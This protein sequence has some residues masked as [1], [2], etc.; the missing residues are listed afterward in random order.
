LTEVE[1]IVLGGSAIKYQKVMFKIGRIL[2]E[3]CYEQR[4]RREF[5]NVVEFVTICAGLCQGCTNW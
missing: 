3:F 2:A 4:S 1:E 5:G